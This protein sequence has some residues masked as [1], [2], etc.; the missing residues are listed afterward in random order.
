MTNT[1]FI[2]KSLLKNVEKNYGV[3]FMH[4]ISENIEWLR[5]SANFIYRNN[6]N[7]FVYMKINQNFLHNNTI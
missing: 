5:T 3:F 1:M 6:S 7:F 4:T 2:K